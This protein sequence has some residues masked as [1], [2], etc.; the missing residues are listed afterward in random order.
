MT[1]AEINNAK[2]I[3]FNNDMVRALLSGVKTETRRIIKNPELQRYADYYTFCGLSSEFK[4][5]AAV[6]KFIR[7]PVVIN[8]DLF[9][10]VKAKC[11]IGDLFYVRESTNKNPLLSEHRYRAD[12]HHDKLHQWKPNIHMLASDARIFLRV[13][14]I[15]A[16]RLL[17]IDDDGAVR[18]GVCFDSRYKWYPPDWYNFSETPRANFLNLW[19]SINGKLEGAN[20]WVLVYCFEVMDRDGQPISIL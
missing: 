5:S 1:Q 4:G 3:L 2:P 9:R 19:E 6:L 20:P 13:T 7:E 15:R 8:S 18:E 16:E 10:H 17:Q 14:D 11:A 12:T